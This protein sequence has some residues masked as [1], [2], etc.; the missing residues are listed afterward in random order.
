MRSSSRHPF[1]GSGR[2]CR[3]Y[4][5]DLRYRTLNFVAVIAYIRARRRLW[6]AVGLLVGLILIGWD[7]AVAA[8]T[9]ISQYAVRNDFRLAYAAAK[10]GVED[11]YGHLYDLAAQKA[12]IESLGPGFNPQPFISPPPLAWLVTPLLVLPFAAA[13]VIWTLLL[14]VALVWTWYLLAPPGRIVRTAHL[15]L[16][17]GVF[18]VAF[19]VMVG[20]PGA[21]VAAAVA[22]AWW[23][24]KHDRP[25]W[26]GLVL[27]LIVLKPQ[28]ALL[29]PLCLLVSGHARTFGAWLVTSLFIGLVALA[30]LGPE[31]VARYRD[32]LA[33]T[34][35]PAWNITRGFSIS[36]PLGLGPI[37]TV[38]QV[39]VLAVTL[40]AAWRRRGGGPELPMAAGIVGSLLTTPYL[41][42]QDFLMLI[43][44]GWLVI[45]AG[46]T[47]WQVAL[48]VVGYALL[49]LSLVVLALPILFAE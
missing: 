11:G 46:A 9:F 39:A 43:L 12:A 26:A 45:R 36:G 1:L 44:A 29:V 47:T 48:F 14:L 23:L 34:Q 2:Q 25:A 30:L 4:A 33:Q 16:L 31:G 42:F 7:V 3:E 32:A 18:P 6:P 5:A 20:Q 37:L 35:T 27:S 28:L 10:V 40:L 17:L 41:G 49:D 15:V 22:T 38:T 13:L 24:I 19:G 8:P 21:W